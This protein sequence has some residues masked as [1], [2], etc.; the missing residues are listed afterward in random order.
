MSDQFTTTLDRLSRITGVR[1][2]LIV[3]AEANC[4]GD[5]RRLRDCFGR[6]R[7]GDRT[8]SRESDSRI[9]PNDPGNAFPDRC[10]PVSVS[11]AFATHCA[12]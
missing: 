11:S 12:S 8:D 2:A 7:A 3:E 4:G 6:R 9:A 5:R 10:R 1:G